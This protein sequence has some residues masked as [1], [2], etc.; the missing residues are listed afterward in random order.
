MYFI[1]MIKLYS[2]LYSKSFHIFRKLAPRQNSARLHSPTSSQLEGT[3]TTNG[4]PSKTRIIQYNLSSHK[5]PNLQ[6]QQLAT[7]VVHRCKL[8]PVWQLET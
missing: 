6:S 8:E 5:A 4:V 7:T 3:S 2:I 1:I